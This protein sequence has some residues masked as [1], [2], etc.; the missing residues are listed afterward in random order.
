MTKAKSYPTFLVDIQVKSQPDF[1]L[2]AFLEI[3]T[4][5]FDHQIKQSQ[6]EEIAQ[7]AGNVPLCKIVSM[8]HELAVEKLL[9][10]NQTCK[11]NGIQPFEFVL[12]TR[13]WK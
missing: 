5:A 10:V 12:T 13:E 3:I 2:S 4:D 6:L 7:Y 9:L 11:Y 1:N 8:P